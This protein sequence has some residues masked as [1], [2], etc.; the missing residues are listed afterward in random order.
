M[1]LLRQKSDLVLCC[2][3]GGGRRTRCKRKPPDLVRGGGAFDV[4]TMEGLLYL[5]ALLVVES[6]DSSLPGIF[7]RTGE[8]FDQEREQFVQLLG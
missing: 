3:G 6:Q 7:T 4:D 2:V 1:I 8:P 5:E